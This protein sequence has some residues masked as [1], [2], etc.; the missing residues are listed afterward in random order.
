MHMF[1]KI[2]LQIKTFEKLYNGIEDALIDVSEI[3]RLK[4]GFLCTVTDHEDD[5]SS[6]AVYQ[7][8]LYPL[9]ISKL[10]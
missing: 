9:K 4:S 1:E 10:I 2:S 8:V 3:R 5:F 6:K 7:N